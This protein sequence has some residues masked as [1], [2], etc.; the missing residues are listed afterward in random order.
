MSKDTFDVNFVGKDGKEVHSQY[1]NDAKGMRRF[2]SALD[3]CCEVLMEAMVEQIDKVLDKMQLLNDGVPNNAAAMLFGTNTYEYPQFKL[4]MARFRGND[5]LSFIDNKQAE[6]NFFDLLDAGMSFFFKHL[7]LSGEIKGLVR[8]E[9]LEIPVEAL[10]EALINALCHRQYEKYNL[11]IGIAIYDDRV[12]IENP[13]VLPPQLTP[14]TI[15]MSHASYPYNPIIA[16][17]LYKTTFLEK[18]GSGIGRI[19]DACHNHDI[20]N[21]SWKVDGGFVIVSFLRKSAENSSDVTKNVTK[22]VT[23]DVT[24]NVT[25]ANKIDS[26]IEKHIL[27]RPNITTEE[28]ASLLGVTKRTVLRHIAKMTNIQ[29]VGGKTNGHWEVIGK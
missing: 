7:S 15:M 5:K 1:D 23:K 14:E 21:P 29:F 3:R 16:D 18:W 4:R 26:L 8:E 20:P 28:I 24:K 10:R 19:M 11:T 27:D 6:G 17:I 25:K 12:E 13:G 9:Q 2:V 22:D